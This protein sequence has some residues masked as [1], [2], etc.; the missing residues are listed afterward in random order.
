MT[1]LLDLLHPDGVANRITVM[2]SAAPAMLRLG[3]RTAAMNGEL[4]DAVVLAPDLTECRT[5]NWLD[6]A[7]EAIAGGLASN[8]VVYV[9]APR[10]W[11]RSVLRLL[12]QRGFIVEATYAHLRQGHATHYAI[13]CDAAI[14][15]RVVRGLTA[16]R[17][18]V[19]LAGLFC[20]LPGA[21]AVARRAW[22]V[23][24]Y[25]VRRPAARAAFDWMAPHS[26]AFGTARRVLVREKSRCG[27]VTAVVSSFPAAGE[28]PA[29]VVKVPL[30][31]DAC[32]QRAH[33]ASMLTRLQ[34]AA[35]L[36]GATLPVPGMFR[37]TSGRCALGLSVIDGEPA[38]AVL[39]SRPERLSEIV[40]G[41]GG[42]LERWNLLTQRDAIADAARLSREI[43]EPAAAIAQHISCGPQY[44]RWLE[45]RC[46][47]VEG[48]SL[49][50]V[51]T[52]NDLTVSNVLL[53]DATRLGVLDWEVARED[54][55]PLTDLFYAAADAHAATRHPRARA[56]S[57]IEA[58][59]A[60]SRAGRMVDRIAGRLTDALGINDDIAELLKHASA[61]LHAAN[62]EQAKRSGSR[63]FLELVDWLARTTCVP[64]RS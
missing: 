25:V 31:D 36:A 56:Q 51:A 27:G 61:L 45:E 59:D 63:P 55:L 14:A 38:S 16:S 21:A 60:N 34:A 28:R 11:R 15:S 19:V 62:E 32:R 17:S 20:A 13:P 23:V 47:A 33:E 3:D 30:T 46:A 1:S 2:G 8:G 54:G 4:L 29:C 24:G 39:A 49:P 48:Q 44:L 10:T 58:F 43:L 53:T 52:H 64:A 35:S 42:W 9:V 5:A 18:K 37:L 7:V 26:A 12:S 40:A 50:A 57:L 22:P 6:D 41:I